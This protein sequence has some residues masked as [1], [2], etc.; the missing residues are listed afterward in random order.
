MNQR[1]D[2]P[3]EMDPGWVS[4]IES[5]WQSDPKDRPTFRELLEKLKRLQRLQAQASRLAQ[6]SQTTTPTPEI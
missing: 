4:I 1:L 6:G 5:C 3:K 2:I